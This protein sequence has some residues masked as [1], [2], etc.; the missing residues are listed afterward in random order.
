MQAVILAA[1]KSTRTYPLTLT[2]PKPLLK[3]ANKTILEHN[4]DSLNNLADEAIVILGYKK[5]SIKKRF[6]SKYKNLKIRYVEQKQ[7]LGTGHAVS[8]AEKFIKGRFILLAG[9]DVY[10][11][12]D[13]KNCIRHQY[14][15]LTAKV[16]NPQNFGVII[17]KNG[18]LA[19]F[20]EK[21]KKN[22]SDTISTSLYV[23]DKK[24]FSYIKKIKKS[25]RN[26]IEMPDAVN[27]LSKDEKVYCVASKLWLPIGYPWDLLKADLILRKGKN[28]IGKKSKI[29][30]RVLNSSIGVNCKVKGFV[31]N[32]I[33]MDNSII[34]KDSIVKDSVIGENVCFRGKINSTGN[35]SSFV[36]G[37]I[38]KTGRFGAVI[39]DN[40]F[41]K[42][43]VILP[44]SKIWPA[45]R[46][47]NQ[48]IAKDII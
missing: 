2:K 5:N 14:S 3:A 43:V 20:I 37:K 44:G 21:P 9:D 13:I 42:N 17:A 23:L 35:S 6:G 41:V 30:G 10:S 16:E 7:Q 22:L 46:I 12:Q 48:T 25:E 34:E 39:G 4:L 11:R 38:I 18:I 32:S 19:D 28:F 27:L 40:A 24:I 47:I 26:E 31:K 15:I 33:I 29:L 45:K 36:N 1:G 8:L